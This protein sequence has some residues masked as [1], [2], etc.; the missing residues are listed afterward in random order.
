[1]KKSVSYTK[2]ADDDDEL[3]SATS[4][5]GLRRKRSERKINDIKSLS[6]F[7]HRLNGT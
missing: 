3:K 6:Q 4:S 2:I 5:P 7:D 1:M